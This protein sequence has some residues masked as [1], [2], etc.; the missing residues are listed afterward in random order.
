MLNEEKE[1]L[2]LEDKEPQEDCECEK[3]PPKKYL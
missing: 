1:L 2:S 3:E